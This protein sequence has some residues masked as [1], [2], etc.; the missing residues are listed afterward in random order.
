MKRV[1]VAALAAALTM[2]LAT[3]TPLAAGKKKT[4]RA[5]HKKGRPAAAEVAAPPAESDGA[6]GDAEP[7]AKPAKK[8]DRVSDDELKRILDGA[9]PA[10]S[11]KKAPVAEKEE[12]VQ[13]DRPAPEAEPA[14]APKPEPAPLPPPKKKKAKKLT[15]EAEASA[16]KPEPRPEALTLAVGGAV[17]QRSFKF[18]EAGADLMNYS[19]S[20]FLNQAAVSLDWYPGAH[21]TSGIGAHIGFGASYHHVFGLSS[22]VRGADGS[23]PTFPTTVNG[24]A[25]GV[26]IRIPAGPIDFVLAGNYGAQQFTISSTATAARPTQLPNVNTRYMEGGLNLRILLG[27]IVAL[28]GHGS[29]RFVLGKG[30]AGDMGEINSASWFPHAAA[31][32]LNAGGGVGVIVTPGFEVR[33]SGDVTRF[34]F[35][36]NVPSDQTTPPIASGAVDQYLRGMLSLVLHLGGPIGF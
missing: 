15:T 13:P 12:E 17:W 29:Y 18:R 1:L 22:Q 9:P 31:W 11:Q 30:S 6:L 8:N 28:Y 10:K 2:V 35:T 34:T 23:A 25:A 7:A 21:F 19:P 14:A 33:A 4:K 3:G 16:R 20:L 27:R 24:Y 32:G 36:M 5:V 26:R